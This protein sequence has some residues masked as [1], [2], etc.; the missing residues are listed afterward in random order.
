MLD[1]ARYFLAL[2]TLVTYPF[3]LAFWLLVHPFVKFWRRL[4]PAISYSILILL[5]VLFGVAAW[6][7]RGPLLAVEYGTGPALWIAAALLYAL[8]FTIERSCRR[9]L[10]LSILV[11]L[12]EL[13]REGGDAVLLSDGIYGRVRHPRYLAVFAGTLAVALFSNYLATWIVAVATPLALLA[14]VHFEERELRE[15]FG[16]AYDEYAQRVPRFVPRRSS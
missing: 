7:V 13:R 16:A 10:K 9:H 15:R 6:R 8:A 14:I 3:A 1:E 12:P 4:G 11:G 5:A 2:L